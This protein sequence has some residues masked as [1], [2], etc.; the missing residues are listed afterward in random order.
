MATLEQILEEAR[1]LTPD[2]RRQLRE[3][4]DREARPAVGTASDSQP[5]RQASEQQWI[6]QHR[7]EYLGQWVVLEGDRLIVHGH[8]ARSVYQAAREAGVT[9]PF[10]VRVKPVDE[11][12]FGGW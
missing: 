5:L 2:E 10:L 6:A 4:L 7:D 8:D 3:A 11:L 12:P 9:A 1:A